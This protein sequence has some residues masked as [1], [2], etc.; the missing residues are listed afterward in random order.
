MTVSLMKT[1]FT[2]CGNLP[3]SDTTVR[4]SLIVYANYVNYLN[5]YSMATQCGHPA[6]TVNLPPPDAQQ[7]KMLSDS[8][9][10]AFAMYTMLD[11]L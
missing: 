3:D 6:D 1:G 4:K 8:C 9:N 5:L 10:V 7:L 11:D 2:A